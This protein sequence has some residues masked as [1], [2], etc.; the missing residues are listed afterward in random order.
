MRNSLVQ[1]IK[2]TL[3]FQF[4]LPNGELEKTIYSTHDDHCYFVDGQDNFVKLIYNSLIEYSF[5]SK[6]LEDDK[7]YN[8]LLPIAIHSRFH[9][10]EDAK[11]KTKISYGFY[12][13][14][15]LYS[16]LKVIYGVNALVSRGF[17]YNPTERAET[18]GY[19]AYHIIASNNQL[20]L[21]FGEAKFYQKFDKAIKSVMDNFEKALSDKYLNINLWAIIKQEDKLENPPIALENLLED[22]KENPE[23]KIN[24]LVNKHNMTL[25]YPILII[26]NNPEKEYRRC[27]QKLV[28]EIKF[29]YAN[30]TISLSIPYKIFFIFMPVDDVKTIKEKVIECIEMRS[31]L[32]T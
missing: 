15:V 2:N 23:I 29:K 14:V 9:F 16:L 22:I 30:K 26:C 1:L 27:I 17:F 7:D 3:L 19:D 8:K 12:G 32:L 11:N 21:W 4:Y 31:P 28:E 18:K 5:S 25:V 10:D 6:E 24:E 13:E 20:D